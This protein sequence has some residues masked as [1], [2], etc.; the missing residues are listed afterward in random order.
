MKPLLF[1]FLLLITTRTLSVSIL[2]P[3]PPTRES[4]TLQMKFEQLAPFPIAP[5]LIEQPGYTL[6]NV[7]Q[8]FQQMYSEGFTAV[9]QIL[10][11][12]S[13]QE[14][15]EEY[16]NR[17]KEW[18]HIALDAGL[19][20][21]WYQ[22]GG[23]ECFTIEL[24]TELNLSFNLTPWELEVEPVMIAYQLAL[25]KSR[26]DSMTSL[27]VFNLGEPGAGNPII[28]SSL[29]PAFSQWLNSTYNGD[30][31]SLLLAW[32]DPYRSNFT[33]LEANDFLSAATL[34]SL[35]TNGWPSHDYRRYRDSMR[36]QADA[37]LIRIN[38]SI[39][40]LLGNDINAPVRTGGASLQLNQAYYSWDLFNQG[41]LAI[42]A[43]S[44]YISSHLSWHY[45][46][47]QH[48]IDRPV[49]FE[50]S[51]AVA[52]ANAG[53]FL[54]SGEE[55]YGAWPG[56]WEST[57]GPSQYS[58]GQATSVG[59]GGITKL[60][61]TYIALGM[62]G[63]GLWTYN[64]RPKGQEMGEYALT[65]LQ[66]K[67]SARS[68]AAGLISKAANLY[69]WE[70]WKSTIEPL[71]AILY[72][73]ENEALSGRL[74]MQEP[75]FECSLE[76]LDCQY[77]T[78]REQGA[79]NRA[80]FGWV[81]A[82]VDGHIPFTH[83]DEDMIRANALNSNS[84]KSVKVL[85]LTHQLG[86][87][88]DLFPILLTWQKGGGRIVV[89]Q[90]FL[91]MDLPSG[92]LIDQSISL[93]KELFG[94]YITE[95][96]SVETPFD[97]QAMSLDLGNGSIHYLGRGQYSYFQVT[98]A[99]LS[100]SFLPPFNDIPA[101]FENIVGVNGGSSAFINFE[102]GSH[103]AL[104]SDLKI[105][106]STG[107]NSNITQTL[108]LSQWMI[109]IALGSSSSTSSSTSI[110]SI[111]PSWTASP[112][113]IPVFLRSSFFN[114]TSVRHIFAFYDDLVAPSLLLQG[115]IGIE[116]TLELLWNTTRDVFD[117]ITGESISFTVTENK[118]IIKFLIG[119]RSARWLRT[120]DG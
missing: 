11:S 94:V 43:G 96:N 101:V 70:L 40:T 71:V 59:A 86:L 38:N 27:P 83:V 75:T 56:E 78:S 5:V 82:L 18:F 16:L 64:S 28:S 102:A 117:V 19:S 61:L 119:F 115:E 76:E 58:G 32:Q 51:T 68:K 17:T 30:I 6:T 91:L 63:I 73:W 112:F 118:T 87:S 3:Y 22:K 29:I 99:I 50:I 2:Y 95:Y 26:I 7:S 103:A 24:L 62:K 116:V 69:R 54:S 15:D 10:L 48:E 14:S 55:S 93:S 113:G 100:Q 104:P 34:L 67:P 37:F 41:R 88:I 120:I 13:L 25:Q 109:N 60:L 72:S 89:D 80:R 66:G 36:F 45:A 110:T 23:W 42:R 35:P 92:W 65:T 98:D 49:I 53:A 4:C 20:P 77:F 108:A 79:P 8:M 12:V 9:K 111:Q 106:S 105:A 81:R 46:G 44:F 84:L 57:G 52:A 97:G 39:T 31:N 114:N 90:P 47:Y 107:I 21:W 33:I 85:V 74:S 1:L